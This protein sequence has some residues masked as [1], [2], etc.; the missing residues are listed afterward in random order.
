MDWPTT[1]AAFQA[2]FD[3]LN[4]QYSPTLVTDL[5]RAIKN[6]LS[7]YPTASE[8]D[9][10]AAYQAIMSKV[11][12]INTLKSS[13]QTLN[14]DIIKLFKNE[15]VNYNLSSILND[16]GELQ[17]KIRQLKKKQKE[18]DVDVESAVAREELLRSRDKNINSH[19]LFLLDRPI[20][21]SIVPYLWVLSVLCIGIALLFFRDM[22]PNMGMN[23][24]QT[25]GQWYA[26]ITN[27]LLSTNVLLGLL[28]TAIIAIVFLSLKVGGVFDK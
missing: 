16:N 12:V 18:A 9:K 10:T 23:S 14:D 8:A 21:Q 15:A 20:R 28:I 3:A 2:R 6:Y 1:R 24:T 26:M 11:N 4:S 22:T 7:T 27:V 5:D 17:A 13:Y 19:Q 25:F